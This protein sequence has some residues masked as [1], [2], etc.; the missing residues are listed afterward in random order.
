MTTG[1]IIVAALEILKMKSTKEVPSD[2]VITDPLNAWMQTSEERKAIL[3]DI[4]QLIVNEFVD[5]SFPTEESF[6]TDDKVFHMQSR[7]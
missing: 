3:K 7:F 4:C 1:H 5:F 2:V 6:T